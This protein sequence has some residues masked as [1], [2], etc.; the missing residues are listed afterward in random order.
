M[1]KHSQSS[2]S[3]GSSQWPFGP[4]TT[5]VTVSTSDGIIQSGE[6]NGRDQR[7]HEEAQKAAQDKVD[8]VRESQGD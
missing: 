4:D 5:V 1:S 6:A 2:R 7:A 3:Y 8:R